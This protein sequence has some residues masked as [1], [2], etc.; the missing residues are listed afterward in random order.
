MAEMTEGERQAQFQHDINIINRQADSKI[1]KL[2]ANYS[3]IEQQHLA[4]VQIK[5]S[6]INKKTAARVQKLIDEQHVFEEGWKK[7]LEAKMRAS[8]QKYNDLREALELAGNQEINGFVER[9][10]RELDT[11]EANF[12]LDIEKIEVWRRAESADEV[13]QLQTHTQRPRKD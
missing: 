13:R 8:Q 2:K 9:D 1:A 4:I 10:M 12:N 6:E 5:S 3:K 7:E 11:I